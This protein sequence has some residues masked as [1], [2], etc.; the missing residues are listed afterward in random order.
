MLELFEECVG[1]Y[2][3]RREWRKFFRQEVQITTKTLRCRRW[4]GRRRRGGAKGLLGGQIIRP[5][6]GQSKMNLTSLQVI[7]SH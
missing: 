5:L 4:R 3:E 6:G 2:Y 7:G 1:V